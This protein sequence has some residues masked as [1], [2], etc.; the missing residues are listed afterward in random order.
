MLAFTLFSCTHM[1]QVKEFAAGTQLDLQRQIKAWEARAVM[2]EEQLAHLQVRMC[3]R[4]SGLRHLVTWWSESW[5]G[6]A[7]SWQGSARQAVADGT[8]RQCSC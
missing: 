1:L 4:Q 2:A 5:Q 8:L 3:E 6:F 7:V